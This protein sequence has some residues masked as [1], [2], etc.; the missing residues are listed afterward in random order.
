MIRR[1]TFLCSC[2]VHFNFCSV[3]T[4]PVE[5]YLFNTQF[6]GISH[7][8]IRRYRGNYRSD[9]PISHCCAVIPKTEVCVFHALENS[10]YISA[11]KY[12]KV[13]KH[14]SV[15]LG[16]SPKIFH[17]RLIASLLEIWDLSAE[18]LP[19]QGHT[20]IVSVQKYNRNT[21]NMDLC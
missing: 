6:S 17:C 12:C 9:K 13:S 8:N 16:K 19:Y 10:P 18:R 5:N 21:F 20:Y 7:P 3:G 2:P 1:L 14:R 4:R 11:R 15:W